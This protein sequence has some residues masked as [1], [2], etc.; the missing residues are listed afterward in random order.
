MLNQVLVSY[1]I[2]FKAFQNNIGLSIKDEPI[3]L[4]K[5][6]GERTPYDPTIK[7]HCEVLKLRPRSTVEFAPTYCARLCGRN[8]IQL[9]LT[10]PFVGAR[11]T[12]VREVQSERFLNDILN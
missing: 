6:L 7:I 11:N 12:R 3:Q 1:R 2:I 4:D 8:I 9:A 10:A 5:M